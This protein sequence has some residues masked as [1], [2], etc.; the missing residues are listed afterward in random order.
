[1]KRLI[2]QLLLSLCICIGIIVG[3]C[4]CFDKTTNKTFEKAGLT[5]TLTTEFHEKEHVEYTAYYASS[6]MIVLTVKE[7]FDSFKKVGQDAE[8]MSVEDYARL[9]IDTYK[10]FYNSASEISIEENMVSFIYENDA[11]GKDYKYIWYG[12]KAVDAFWAVQFGCVESDFDY[13]QS[14]MLEYVKT[15]EIERFQ[16][17]LDF[18]KVEGKEEYRVVG[19]G[20]VCDLDIVIPETYNSLPVTEIADAAF[21]FSPLTSVFIP[22]SVTTIGVTAFAR[23]EDLRSVTFGEKVQT[24]GYRAF[25][26][27]SALESIEIPDSVTT[28]GWRAFADCWVM[29]E[30]KLGGGLT[31]IED[32]VFQGCNDLE[33][34]NISEG[35]TFLGANMFSGCES[36]TNVTLPN[37]LTTIKM[38]AL[39]ACYDLKNIE[40][41]KGLTSLGSCAFRHCSA[42]ERIVI[43]DSV[44]EIQDSVFQG[45]KSLKTA[46]L[47]ANSV[48]V[49]DSMFDGC[50]K[51][52]EF[53]IPDSVHTIGN[54]AFAEC[55]S[56]RE[57]LIP[58]SV[59][60]IGKQAF[61]GCGSLTEI[62]LPD[63]VEFIGFQA[64]YSCS[65]LCDV[66][67]GNGIN[68]LEADM[69]GYCI[70]L[71]E[72]TIP[73]TVT[74]IG[75][76]VFGFCTGLVRITIPDGVSTISENVFSGCEKLES[77]TLGENVS[78]IKDELYGCSSLI[79]FEVDTE[80][81]YY[82][83][84]DGVLYTKDEKVLLKYPQGKKD[85]CFEVPDFITRIREKSF[86]DC[87]YLQEIILPQSV[88]DIGERAFE[89]CLALENV[90]IPDGVTKLEEGTFY[91]CSALKTLNIP[92]SV[93]AIAD[94]VFY[95]CTN[96]KTIVIPDGVS[97][98]GSSVF[99][100]CTNLVI[101]CEV[102]SMPVLWQTKYEWDY[103][104]Y[105]VVWGYNNVTT[106]EMYDYVVHDEEASLTRYKGS[107][108]EIVIPA[109]IDG[110]KVVRFGDIFKNNKTIAS[111][112]IPDGI[113]VIAD[114]AFYGCTELI[115]IEIPDRMI[116]VGYQAFYNCGK[117]CNVLNLKNVTSINISAFEGCGSLK[118]VV[119]S[120][121]LAYVGYYLFSNTDLTNIYYVGTMESW[122]KKIEELT[123][124]NYLRGYTMYYYSEEQPIAE[125]NYWHYDKNG[126][127]TIW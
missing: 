104:P 87:V 34:V 46:N 47:P 109:S 45:C 35:A 75:E 103:S 29:T 123:N 4:G 127:I 22:D 36:L 119:L 12:F 37:S 99:Y 113:K 66:A 82:T 88:T 13:L 2:G 80:N 32:S 9:V 25:E 86:Q 90:N 15:V 106:H 52:A 91:G 78:V 27:C 111:V 121:E 56:L 114:Q 73:A 125:G 108:A 61:F 44:T 107:E 23:S 28:I 83:A 95:M 102:V 58:S 53:V 84:L 110:Y 30:A 116:A 72:I 68:A 1:M 79:K 20:S 26:N 124:S 41:P 85:I 122:V 55:S 94:F 11:L 96:L 63:S 24:I 48:A 43:P 39:S 60:T 97:N 7:T 101:N 81:A 42:L 100:G 51:L 50:S 112:V 74:S 10:D 49:P 8:T 98:F 64:F 38:H 93:T 71:T 65:Q 92:D 19:L 69:F 33:T 21:S 77:I 115:S 105:T 5:I 89:N 120:D 62:V 70:N 16:E 17:T 40:L 76:R 54:S 18:E 118:S 59:T 6:K 67:L 126:E 14:Q 117:L 3:L 31:T 57:I